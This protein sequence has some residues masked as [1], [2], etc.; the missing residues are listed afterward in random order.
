MSTTNE[1]VQKRVIT[2]WKNQDPPKE[3]VEF[4]DPLF[5]PTANSLLGLDSSG[6]Q[7]DSKAYSEKAKNK[8]II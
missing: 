6:N 1:N 7:V 5:P 3:G 8:I 4:K 2:Y